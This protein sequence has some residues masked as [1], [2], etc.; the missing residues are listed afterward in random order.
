MKVGDTINGKTIL[1]MDNPSDLIPDMLIKV[2][3][4]VVE[5]MDEFT[6]IY[7]PGFENQLTSYKNVKFIRVS[8][9]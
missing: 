1:W 6:Y 2:G 7:S 9:L 5:E 3:E 4:K 8:Q